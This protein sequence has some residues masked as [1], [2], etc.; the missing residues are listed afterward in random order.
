[1]H[2]RTHAG[3][4]SCPDCVLPT[5]VTNGTLSPA[6]TLTYRGWAALADG[7]LTTVG[8][9]G[10]SAGT[11]TGSSTPYMQLQL[12]QAYTDLAGV[13]VY[14]RSDSYAGWQEAQNV[15]VY[16]SPTSAF[17]TDADKVTCV[18][19][20]TG[21]IERTPTFFACAGAS[22]KSIQYVTVQR[23]WTA[24]VAFSLQEVQVIRGTGER[25]S[26]TYRL[27]RGLTDLCCELRRARYQ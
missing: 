7:Q 22:S 19:G 5:F 1:M 9:Y 2:A 23:V 11:N 10:D 24:S 15:S 4:V 12:D 6:N 3:G 25:R 27:G 17:A 8:T 20:F 14:P 18:E 21:L 16:L 13:V 26:C